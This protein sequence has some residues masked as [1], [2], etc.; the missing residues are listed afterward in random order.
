[1][2]HFK[3]KLWIM[4]GII[5]F[6]IIGYLMLINKP[7]EQP[8]EQ[9][10]LIGGINEEKESINNSEEGGE[11]LISATYFGDEWPMN[12]WNSEFTNL[13][14]D[15]QRI[16]SDGFNSIILVIPWRE[17]QP[18]MD[19]IEYN[20][21]AF[22]KLRIAITE[23]EKYDLKVMV[24]IGYTWD[25]YEDKLGEVTERFYKIVYDEDI[26][27][28]W[29]DYCKILYD[30]CSSFS[31]F[32]GGFITWEDFWCNSYLGSSLETEAKRVEYAK[33]I[34]Y[35]AWLE[36]ID[37][38]ELKKCGIESE[39][40]SEAKIPCNS[41][42]DMIL[43]Y[44]YLD[45]FFVELLSDSQK[46]FP[47]LSMEVRTDWD[48]YSDKDGITQFIQHDKTY[49]CSDSSYTTI[50]YSI[51]QGWE[52]KGEKIHHLE[53][54]ERT[55]YILDGILKYNKGKPIY[56]DQF[57]FAD[58]TPGFEMNARLYE[59]EIDE[60]LINIDDTLEQYT[61]GYGIWTYRDYA[62]NLLYNPQFGE[63]E[64]GWTIVDGEIAN[65]NSNNSL[66]IL[67]NGK[68]SQELP[69][70]RNHY[71]GN[72]YVISF[73]VKTEE[74]TSVHVSLGETTVTVKVNQSDNIEVKLNTEEPFIFS[75]ETEGEI[76]I[77]NIK[78]YNFIQEGFLYDL[79]GND[80]S[81]IE[82]VRILNGNISG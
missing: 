19:P 2:K 58:N 79:H 12:F 32:A 9:E 51:S 47:N 13:S 30:T 16:A 41:D 21:R 73:D 66:R 71:N 39:N 18:S 37:E 31:N 49:D 11:Y 1:M 46:Y 82:A 35:Q 61:C 26:R 17:F 74:P 53:A 63:G 55:G 29:Y 67:S 14:G 48:V 81:V 59:D 80:G 62:A 69:A 38:E 4:G 10:Q 50:M 76:E 54:I 23:A 60:Y 36:T 24:R 40:I 7:A 42:A 22:D 68:V 65:T 56:I 72:D 15:L 75:L 43:W 28:A 27:K 8:P 52:N 20:E 78:I 3:K 44:Q 64:D 33:K 70:M 34:G 45:D 6:G 25:Y 57:I 5:C 77:D